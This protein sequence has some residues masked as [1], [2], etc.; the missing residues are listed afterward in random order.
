MSNW[1]WGKAGVFHLGADSNSQF[2]NRLKV[3]AW[4]N[5]KKRKQDMH[6]FSCKASLAN[7]QLILLDISVNC[8]SSFKQMTNFWRVE[9]WN[10]VA[11]ETGTTLTWRAQPLGKGKRTVV[12]TVLPNGYSSLIFLNPWLNCGNVLVF[13]KKQNQEIY[14]CKSLS[15]DLIFSMQGENDK[16]LAHGNLKAR[17]SNIGREGQQSQSV[18][19]SWCC[20]LQSRQQARNSG[21]IS[22]LQFKVSF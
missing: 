9:L 4:L 2:L 1:T 15:F 6:R 13:S 18:G 16:E 20:N 14:T 12:D 11:E 19:Q 5:R 17:K 3:Q 22:M 7:E 8:W 10:F 21:K